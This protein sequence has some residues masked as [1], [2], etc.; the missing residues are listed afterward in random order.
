MRTRRSESGAI[1][2]RREREREMTGKP[3]TATGK[4]RDLRGEG[5]DKGAA[6]LES[7]GTKQ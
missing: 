2:E 3:Q 5:S 6:S 7:H 1:H 4:Q